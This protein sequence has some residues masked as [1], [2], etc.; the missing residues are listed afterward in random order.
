MIKNSFGLVL[1]FGLLLFFSCDQQQEQKSGDGILAGKVTIGPLCPVETDPPDP[2]CLPTEETYKAWPIAVLSANG[3]H[4]ITQLHPNLDGT[5]NVEL[6]GGNYLVNLENQSSYGP[7]SS[8]LPS[9]IEI[10]PSDTTYLDIDID[11]GIR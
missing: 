4:L 11:T 1:I 2:G 3:N 6:S 5:Y 9:F 7:G 8:N 10:S